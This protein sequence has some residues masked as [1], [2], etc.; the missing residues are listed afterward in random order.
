[1]ADQKKKKRK[2]CS[3]AGCKNKVSAKGLCS[4]HYKKMWLE[5]TAANPSER[6]PP[7]KCLVEGCGKKHLAKGLCSLH[8]QRVRRLDA[9]HG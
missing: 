1:M 5:K 8:Y 9:T 2:R 4:K 7:R 3:E 6:P